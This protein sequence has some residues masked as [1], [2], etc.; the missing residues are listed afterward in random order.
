MHEQEQDTARSVTDGLQTVNYVADAGGRQE[1]VP[2]FVWQPVDVV[3]RQAWQEIAQ[4]IAASRVLVESG[5]ASCLHYY[6]TAN[7]MDTALMASYTGQSRWWVRLHLRP[8]CFRRLSRRT[9]EKYAELFQ[10][11]VEDLACGR[12]LAP[13]YEQ[14]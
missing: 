11:R 12:L 4:H 13:V 10:V 5:Q 7:Q 14:Q 8:W 6:M 3:N 1:L 2:G 9:L